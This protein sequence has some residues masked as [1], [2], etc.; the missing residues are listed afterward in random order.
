MIKY[1]FELTKA[2][3]L[4][5][6]HRQRG[7]GSSP[8]PI[9][10]RAP[11]LGLRNF[12][13]ISQRTDP[14]QVR[15]QFLLRDRILLL[16]FQIFKIIFKAKHVRW[17]KGSMFSCEEFLNVGEPDMRKRNFSPAHLPMKYFNS[18]N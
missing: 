16:H 7:A 18:A 4:V 13:E 2:L 10:P 1:L 6:I 14:C 8:V 17:S 3:N 15:P 12:A 11:I 9:V 5:V